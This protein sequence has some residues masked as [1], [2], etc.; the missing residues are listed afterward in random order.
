MD[1]MLKN[2]VEKSKEPSK[3]Q[4]HSNN[5]QPTSKLSTQ[6]KNLVPLLTLTLNTLRSHPSPMLRH[7]CSVFAK[8]LLLSCGG[9]EVD[10]VLVDSIMLWL[11]RGEGKEAEVRANDATV[12]FL[13]WSN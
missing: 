8:V 4:S 6:T 3:S 12:N 1:T 5:Q 2:L 13:R 9:G 11:G 7:S 10:A